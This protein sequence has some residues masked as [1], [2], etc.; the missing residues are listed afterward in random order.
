[1][2][3]NYGGISTEWEYHIFTKHLQLLVYQTSTDKIRHQCV[4]MFDIV[5]DSVSKVA[6]GLYL[7]EQI[8]NS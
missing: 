4:P 3:K 1:M 7:L 5:S 8:L 2:E 6:P